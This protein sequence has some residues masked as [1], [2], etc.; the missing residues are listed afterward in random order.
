MGRSRFLAALISI[1]A[2][3]ALATPVLAATPSPTSDLIAGPPSTAW[4]VFAADTGAKSATDLYGSSAS[5]VRGFGDAYQ[6]VWS[7]TGEF[8]FDRVARFT[9]VLW[10]A[11]HFG[12]SKGAAQKNKS[13]TSYQ[14]VSGFG[15]GAYE[16]TDPADSNGYRWDTMVFTEGDYVS[17]IALAV[18]DVTISHF[19]VLDQA[20]RQLALLPFPTGE[21][22]ALGTSVLAGSVVVLLVL[23]GFLLSAGIIVF[24]VVRRRRPVA[25]ASAYAIA[26]VLPPGAYQY[27]AVSAAVAVAA[28]SFSS[29]RRFWWDGSIWQDTAA[30][31]PAGVPTS[32]DGTQWWDGAAWRPVPG[33][34]A[35]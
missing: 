35:R 25:P 27:P 2:A 28:P 13:H 12:G 5:S 24:V 30:R 26:G 10:A 3:A 20:S 29:D 23:V 7:R 17:L 31:I 16:F 9:T 19:I 22:S 4:Q 32:P 15:T 1:V 6:K 33:S 11:F 14:S 34:A 18:N 21:Y 8:L